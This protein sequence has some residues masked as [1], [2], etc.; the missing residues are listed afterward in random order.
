MPRTATGMTPDFIMNPHAIP[1]RMTIGQLLENLLGKAA[2]N[3]G[4]IGN[5]TAFMNQGSPHEEIGVQLE[6]L[7][8]EKYGNEILYNGMT[9]EQIPSAIFIAPVFA[10]RLKH[11]TED[12]WN[13][14]GQGRREQRTH[15]P[16]GGRGAQ[17]G[18][19]IGEMERDAISAHGIS[20]FTRESFMKRSD[21]TT[22][23]VCEGCGTIPIYNERQNLY[24]CPLCD[25]PLQYAGE[26]SKNIELIPPVKRAKARFSRIEAPY[27]MMLLGQELESYMNISMRYLTQK[28][29]RTLKTNTPITGPVDRTMANT[30]LPVRP[31]PLPQATA[32]T[33]PSEQET[34][35]GS[36]VTAITGEQQ[37]SQPQQQQQQ[38]QPQ[39]KDESPLEN[40][41]TMP[42]I[43]DTLKNVKSL[44]QF[45][46]EQQ[47]VALEMPQQLIE[48][49]TPQGLPQG[50]PQ[51][52]QQQ[53]SPQGLPQGSQQIRFTEPQQQG[54]PP[55]QGERP[56]PPPP[57]QVVASPTSVAPVI[58]VDTTPSAMTAEGITQQQPQPQQQR[59]IRIKRP[60]PIGGSEGDED[61]Q[62]QIHTNYSQNVSF[63]KL[64]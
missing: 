24:I 51:G 26:S 5:G 54:P 36:V 64:S 29:L 39:Q 7:G 57:A 38:S 47:E 53:G 50:L 33:L 30:P 6:R 59:I 17:G 42:Q 32:P 61:K 10:M 40:M 21:G 14:R 9:G 1:S 43:P 60:N 63:V 25:G 18:L 46:A 13:V 52:S 23:I 34:L 15:Q 22:F 41:G 4:T 28:S 55:V 20:A 11:M 19:R 37:Q 56:A 12:K 16:T 31:P 62:E 58:M 2:A 45:V 44:E 8:F 3:I 49:T 27:A 35:L 48:A